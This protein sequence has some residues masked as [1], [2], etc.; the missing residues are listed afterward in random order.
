MKRLK[1]IMI[2]LACTLISM[3]VQAQGNEKPRPKVAV[4][5]SGGGAKGMAHIGALR[6]IERAGIPV[7]IVTGTSMG[8]IIGGLY[9]I[10]YDSWRLDSLVRNQDWMFLLSDK[11]ERSKMSLADRE[12]N[13]TYILS[14]TINLKKKLNQSGFIVGKNLD[15]LFFRLT[16]GYHDSLDFNSL[17]IP[18]ACVATNIVD[19]TEYDFHGG[20][21]ALAM[22]SSMAIPGVFT[23]VRLG[24]KI[25]VDGGL[26]NNFPVDIAR[27]MGADYV[28]GVSVQGPP[29]TAEDLVNGASVLGQII[30]INCKNKY[31]DNLAHTDVPVRVDVKGYSAA[32][33]T[34][35]AIDSLIERGEKAAMKHW[36]EL[37]ALK[38]KLGLD[39]DYCAPRMSLYCG[40]D[41]AM[42]DV[43]KDDIK[44]GGNIA[45]SFGARFDMEEMA[46]LQM[47]T[48]LNIP[49]KNDKFEAEATLRLGRRIM[50][51]GDFS[52]RFFK[53]NKTSLSYVFRHNDDFCVY[54][55]GDKVY[56]ITYNQHTIDL[57]LL[58]FNLR[59]F[60]LKFGPG[61]DF[62]TFEDV[63][64]D[65]R[66]VPIP[67][68]SSEHS[69]HYVSYNASVEFNSEDEWYFPTRGAKFSAGYSYITDNF[70]EY[71]DHKGLSIINAMWR[72][73]LPFTR[74]FSMQPM[75]Y[76]RLIYGSNVPGIMSNYVGGNWFAHY[77]RQQ[78]PF[79]GLGHIEYID[80][81]AIAF[82]LQMQEH[83]TENN[84]ILLKAV[85]MQ[86]SDKVKDLLDHKPYMGYQL[87]YYYDTHIVG[88]I[89]ANVG[90]STKSKEPYFYINI[91]YVF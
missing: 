81:H 19:N 14:K 35:N 62:Y 74:R 17:P 68:I 64:F 67:V 13:N 33:F 54:H 5:L 71:K 45:L 90:Y 85:A 30:D 21:L 10:G 72:M 3:S 11:E 61:F 6:V 57:T 73:S 89:G 79:A 1:L 34:P 23:P 46:A 24:D 9:S 48:K 15:K 22:R 25:L 88:P 63:L 28:I 39:A 36:D 83:I 18:F 8:S 43:K 41:T 29:N 49:S 75:L 7:D 58:D 59:N 27:E 20:N 78:M 55:E 66:K 31:D 38:A 44:K 51:R 53:D 60:N 69:E 56:N 82:Q 50:A 4:V 32:S 76:G 12:K 77:N 52:Y 70:A 16:A 42:A 65:G 86:H 47:N 37:L 91:G 84:I 26:R 80:N 87:S 40:P 2:T